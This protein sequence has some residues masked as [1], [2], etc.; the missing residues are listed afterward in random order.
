MI[1]DYVLHY[2]RLQSSEKKSK[3]ANLHFL[4]FVFTK[5]VTHSFLVGYNVSRFFNK[6]RSCKIS[7]ICISICYIIKKRALSPVLY[8]DK[9]KISDLFCRKLRSEHSVLDAVS[10]Q[11]TKS[12][13]FASSRSYYYI[14]RHRASAVP[15][16]PRCCSTWQWSA[17][18]WP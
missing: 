7:T 3:P 17:P 16:Y 13:H 4:G 2:L 11:S 18:H 8:L 12:Q 15:G 5:H 6:L 10:S 14:I 9:N 1:Q